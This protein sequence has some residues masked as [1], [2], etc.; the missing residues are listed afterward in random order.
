MVSKVKMGDIVT[1]N[2][3][4]FLSGFREW[5]L[6]QG[7]NFDSLSFRGIL[8][9]SRKFRTSMGFKIIITDKE[10]NGIR[11]HTNIVTRPKLFLLAKIKYGI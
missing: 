10:F 9:Y 1:I 5:L 11:M 3:I 6:E 2:H 7:M 8:K 4:N